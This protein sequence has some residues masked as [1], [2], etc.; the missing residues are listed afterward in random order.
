M[1]H[2]L[3]E[4]SMDWGGFIPWGSVYLDIIL[5]KWFTQMKLVIE[6]KL[7]IMPHSIALIP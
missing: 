2:K 3:Y 5:T 1:D 7:S 4:Q 6:F